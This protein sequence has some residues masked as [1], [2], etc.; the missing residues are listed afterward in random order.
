MKPF[1]AWIV[2]LPNK[3][4]LRNDNIPELFRTRQLAEKIAAD[5]QGTIQQIVVKINE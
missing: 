5:V 2:R 1:K 4:V 3:A